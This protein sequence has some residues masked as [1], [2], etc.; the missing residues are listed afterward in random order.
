MPKLDIK[1]SSL[2]GRMCCFRTE[3]FRVADF[4]W[5]IE[6]DWCVLRGIDTFAAIKDRSM[7]KY[8][9]FIHKRD[10]KKAFVEKLGI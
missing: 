10:Q 2:D 5:W 7:H 1:P 9:I 3:L 6:E 4:N 8:V